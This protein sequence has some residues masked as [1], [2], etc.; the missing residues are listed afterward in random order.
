MLSIFNF[1]LEEAE[2]KY[3]NRESRDEDLEMIASLK[4]MV[5]EKDQFLFKLNVSLM[6]FLG[7]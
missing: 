5:S 4:E 6:W 7:A 1:R 3:K 2:D